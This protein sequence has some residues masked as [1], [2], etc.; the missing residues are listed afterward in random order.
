MTKKWQAIYIYPDGSAAQLPPTSSVYPRVVTDD[1]NYWTTIGGWEVL[2]WTDRLR[3]FQRRNAF[4][5]GGTLWWVL[6]R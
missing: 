4:K 5:H 3:V 6:Q 1:P 2:A